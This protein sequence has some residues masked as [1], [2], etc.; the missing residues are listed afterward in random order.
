MASRPSGIPNPAATGE[1]R[2]PSLIGRKITRWIDH[3]LGGEL[4]GTAVLAAI[5][6]LVTAGACFLLLAGLAQAARLA[7]GGATDPALATASSYWA[8]RMLV[9]AAGGIVCGVVVRFLVG[10]DG[11]GQEVPELID[12]VARRGGRVR[13]RRSLVKA[14]AS[15]AAIGSGGSAGPEGPIVTAGGAIASALGS[16]AFGLDGQRLKVLVASGASAGIAAL[17]GAPIAGVLFSAEVILKAMQVRALVP[18]AVAAATAAVARHAL[19]DSGLPVATLV[20]PPVAALHMWELGPCL[21]LGV[22]A[23]LVGVVFSHGLHLFQ[24]L[25]EAVPLPSWLLPAVG[26][27]MVG[28]MGLVL[29]EVL[30]SG[31]GTIENLL[32][33]HGVETFGIGVLLALVVWKFLATSVTL[34]S[35]GAGGTFAPALTMGA[36]LGTAFGAAATHLLGGTLDVS[37]EGTYAAVGM[38]AVLAATTHATLTAP[39]LVCEMIRDPAAGHLLP[40]IL[41]SV[42]AVVV[43]TL[44]SR[45]TVHSLPLKRH[46]AGARRATPWNEMVHETPV[47]TLLRSD[48]ERIGAGEPLTRLLKRVLDGGGSLCQHVVDDGGKLLGS[49]SLQEVGPL[50]REDGLDGLL[51][52]HDVMRTPPASVARTDSLATCLE[53]F[54]KADVDE[55]PVVDGAGTLIGRITRKDVLEFY[56]RESLD[57]KALALRFVVRPGEGGTDATDATD[58]PSSIMTDFVEVPPDHL[59]EALPIPPGFVGKS[60]RDLNLRAKHSVTVM[61]MRRQTESGGR[62]SFIAP[63]PGLELRAGDILIVAGPKGKVERLKGLVGSGKDRNRV[64]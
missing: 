14:V 25:F 64:S 46:G 3:A 7:Y 47:S 11:F 43:S 63:D 13:F 40:L 54:A 22:L 41:A 56:A 61:G 52:A 49:V 45:E 57:D 32:S 34:A 26:G 19:L 10:P 35:G 53:R 30:G 58:S 36:A 4:P 16:R 28:V 6:G 59:V 15:L 51:V 62:V 39:V 38:V 33:T 21:L 31:Y 42:T 9:P 37:S 23:G 1:F 29:P 50:L 5:V 24:D 18:L 12:G 8:L 55:L 17:F 48:V 2:A 27:L 60:L 20:L 44:L